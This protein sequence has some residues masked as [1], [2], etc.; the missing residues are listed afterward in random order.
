MN[1]E[2]KSGDFLEDIDIEILIRSGKTD[3][4]TLSKLSQAIVASV[5]ELVDSDVVLAETEQRVNI[6]GPKKLSV[7]KSVLKV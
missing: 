5:V 6:Q 7:L 3:F 2:M 4:R 1:A